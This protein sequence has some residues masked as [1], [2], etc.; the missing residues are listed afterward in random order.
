[1]R[2]RELILNAIFDG[3]SEGE[4]AELVRVQQTR[5]RNRH[6]RE[7]DHIIGEAENLSR[8]TLRKSRLIAQKAKSGN[9]FAQRMIEPLREGR[10]SIDAVYRKLIG[11][12]RVGLYIKIDPDLRERVRAEAFSRNI[13]MTEV[14][15]EIL[16]N[17]LPK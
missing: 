15:T 5:T 10:A 12:E 3:K 2:R 8:E 14:I 9:N 7:T 16:D 4:V 17:Y 11:D 13:S 1:M 6:R